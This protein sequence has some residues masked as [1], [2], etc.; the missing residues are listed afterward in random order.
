MTLPKLKKSLPVLGMG[1]LLDSGQLHLRLFLSCVLFLCIDPNAVPQPASLETLLLDKSIAGAHVGLIFKDIESGAVLFAMNADK[2]FI[3]ASNLKLF[4]S[5]AALQL[6]GPTFRFKTSVA[7]NGQIDYPKRKLEGDLIIEAG[8]DPLISGRFRNDMLEIFRFW[9]DSLKLRGISAISGNILVNNAFF[10]DD[11][12][13]PGWSHDDLSY[14]YACPISAFSFNDNCVDLKISA[15]RKL[16]DACLVRQNPP[17]D[18]IKFVNRIITLPAGLP[19]TIDFYRYPGSDSALIFGG[20]AIDDTAGITE[21]I[22]VAD[23]DRY[24]A[25]VLLHVLR[26]EGIFVSGGIGEIGDFHSVDDG[27]VIF[28]WLSD[29]LPVVLSVINKNSQNFFAEQTLKTIGK[30]L[31]GEG[32]FSV[33]TRVVADW[34]ESIGIT[35]DDVKMADGSGLSALNLVKP[36]AIIS[37]LE[38]M[39]TIPTFEIFYNSMAI[40]GVD[41]SVRN[42][43]PGQPLAGKMRTKTGRIANVSAFSG[44]LT[45]KKGKLIAFAII[46]N[47]AVAPEKELTA[48]QD[49]LCAYFIENY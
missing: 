7:A 4:T 49:K 37:L 26:E 45:S 40:P 5:A 48:W 36:A 34:L 9:A 8:G 35:K 38:Y 20:L 47:G 22:S 13:G 18:F 39:K 24:A 10:E 11:D 25:L 33:S 2:R 27:T 42:R 16:G 43:L 46:I 1:R 32:S 6:L 41:R 19:P 21:Y 29:S 23:P 28:D 15:G 30:T 12:L 44:Y 3:P 31:G 14:W 17:L